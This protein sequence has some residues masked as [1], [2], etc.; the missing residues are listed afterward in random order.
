MLLSLRLGR[1]SVDHLLTDEDFEDVEDQV[2]EALL[3][4]AIE[5]AMHTNRLE[6]FLG[7]DSN[8]FW[9]AQELKSVGLEFNRDVH[10]LDEP[11]SQVLILLHLTDSCE[12]L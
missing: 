10:K 4:P 9:M 2:K 1:D 3:V 12:C 11:A 8:S 7:N 5:L 6:E